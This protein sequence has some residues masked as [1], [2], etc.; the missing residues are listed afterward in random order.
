MNSPI[1]TIKA[2]LAQ[3]EE[4]HKK[5]CLGA[6]IPHYGHSRNCVD[7][8]PINKKIRELTQSLGAAVETIGSEQC[9]CEVGVQCIKCE[10]LSKIAKI[11]AGEN[12][13]T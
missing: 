10:S 3:I 9:F 12:N 11:L 8:R 1:E 13:G 7:T 4:E 5:C 6:T 2:R